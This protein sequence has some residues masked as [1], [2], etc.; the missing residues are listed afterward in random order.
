MVEPI[1]SRSSGD[2]WGVYQN[3]DEP[4]E[5]SAIAQKGKAEAARKQAESHYYSS[6]LQSLKVPSEQPSE[7]HAN[8]TA[9]IET[10]KDSEKTLYQRFTSFTT[11]LWGIFGKGTT[12][13]EVSSN[14]VKETVS[15][16]SVA[17]SPKLQS[18]ERISN[19]RLSQHIADLKRHLYH[20]KEAAEFEAE[21]LR[22]PDSKNMDKLI[23][24]HI[25]RKSLDQRRL[26][27]Q[28]SLG[29]HEDILKLQKVNK[30]LF[31]KHYQ[32][33]E[34]INSLARTDK[35]L[36]WVNI[37]STV[38]IVGMIAAGFITGGVSAVFSVVFCS[39]NVVKGGFSAAQGVMKYQSDLR[40][41]EMAVVDHKA[42]DNH[43]KIN[44]KVTSTLT[45]D[46]EISIVL[47]TIRQHLDT[48]NDQVLR[49]S[50][51]T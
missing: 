49:Q 50:R 39:L 43:S 22:K 5:S 37:G 24:S 42:K 11:W 6:T 41:G 7:T 44:D 19:E 2:L 27:E 20:N 14:T 23:I 16:S 33:L 32:I 34:E 25:V 35:I 17:P 21:M 29:E 30:D 18:P 48:Y 15:S 4:K 47:K 13:A 3:Y 40:Q 26:K 1:S 36:G 28:A 38:G 46:D 51:F 9:S 10:Q 12:P 8:K 45:L 31:K